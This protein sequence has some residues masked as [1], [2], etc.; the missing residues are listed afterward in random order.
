MQGFKKSLKKR[1]ISDEIITVQVN[2]DILNRSF[3]GHPS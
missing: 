1:Q 2:T 3:T